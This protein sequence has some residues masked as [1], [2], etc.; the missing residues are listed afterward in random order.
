[1]TYGRATDD[2][3]PPPAA[4]R[5]PASDR[6]VPPLAAGELHVWRVRIA[7]T[8]HGPS[9]YTGMLSAEEISRAARYSSRGERD[10]YVAVRA[11]LRS[12]LGAYLS[13][14]P[15][16]ISIAYHGRGK[17]ALRGPRSADHALEFNLSHAGALALVAVARGTAVG[18]DVESVREVPRTERVA[19]RVF[20]PDALRRWRELPPEQRLSG[21]FREWTRVEA[22]TKLRGEGL[23]RVAGGQAEHIAR[24]C[25]LRDL[26]LPPG[27]AGAVAMDAAPAGVRW[28]D[29]RAGG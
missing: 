18:V 28:L 5:G 10:R 17:P 29:W 12:L 20:G 23:W 21:F 2:G 8:L 3:E 1:M 27:Y 16:R 25:W 7:P 6:A 13:H 24:D 9:R 4:R 15:A 22:L 11:A 19:T 26:E 14:D